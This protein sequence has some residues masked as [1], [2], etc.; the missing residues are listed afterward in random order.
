[1]EGDAPTEPTADGARRPATT[2]M[3][4]AIVAFC[5]GL[6]VASAIVT[7]SIAIPHN[8]DWAFFRILF[9]LAQ[10]GELRLVGWN[11]MMFFGQLL[12]ALPLAWL[13]GENL[14]VITLANAMV[15]A[16]G[17]VLTYRLAR[18]FLSDEGALVVTISVGVFPGSIALVTTFMTEPSA[19]AA[20][21]ASLLLGLT[22][23]AAR[24]RSRWLYL[25]AALVVGLYGFSIREF[26]I[27]APIAVLIGLFVTEV[28][29]RHF[30][31]ASVGGAVAL[32]AIAAA[33]YTWR[34][35]LGA[36]NTH[37]FGLQL[38]QL[39]YVQI[40]QNFFTVMFGLLIPLL[41]VTARRQAR[42][43]IAALAA[44]AV[45]VALGV[46][47]LS[48]SAGEPTCCLGGNGS[49]FRGN[50]LTER[51]PLGN[52][53]LPGDRPT[54]P[55]ALWLLMTGAALTAGVLVAGRAVAAAGTL[56]RLAREVPADVAVLASFAG[57]TAG[58]ILLRAILGGPTFDRYLTPLV[59]V[60]A[61]LLLRGSGTGDTV[62]TP[63]SVPIAV[64][65]LA[66]VSLGLVAAG[67]SFDAARWEAAEQMVAAGI[68]PGDVDGGFEWVG[69]HYD[70]ITGEQAPARSVPH[71]PGYLYMFPA[72]GNCGVVSSS[73][74]SD[75]R[76]EPLGTI[77]Y[78][79]WFGL[80]K[81]QVWSY[82]FT[83][84][85]SLTQTP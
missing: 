70:G 36:G 66:L 39:L 29:A 82:R 23:I 72:A 33:L 74:A 50:L 49:V 26:A 43:G 18:R 56:P 5:V 59:L 55:A 63:A 53:V 73:P 32:I 34:Q 67:H 3:V 22:A 77:G 6:P 45:V 25:T 12:W 51:G 10:T 27:A 13:A 16:V 40:A 64:A 62:R 37:F 52:Q 42:L 58:A 9:D 41:F 76:F 14:A 24:D 31:A 54:M 30:P 81:E 38:G 46:F 61:I 68:A 83:D 60:G 1:M 11:E 44:G 57:L 65:A 17:L 79:T 84:A 15:A 4:A 78:R 21:L 19:Y 69:Y 48:S 28:R 2:A 85:C 20:Q 47:A 80:K 35:S 8:D 71:G 75:P 7:G